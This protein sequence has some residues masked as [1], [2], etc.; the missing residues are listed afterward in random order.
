MSEKREG[1][2]WWPYLGPYLGFGLIAA[3]GD[4]LPD[5][6]APIMLIVKPGVTA[7]LIGYFWWRGAYPELRGFR[8]GSP[9]V[10]ADL[11]VGVA[12]ALLWMGPYLVFPAIRPADVSGGFDPNMLGASL[13]PA[14]VALR[15]VGYAGVTPIF[16]ELFMRSFVMRFAEVWDGKGDFRNIPIAHYTRNSFLAVVVIFTLAHLPWEYWVM[17]PW[18]ILST[19]WFYWRGHLIAVIVLHAATNGAILLIVARTEGMFLDASGNPLPL[20]FFV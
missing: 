6:A 13:A 18:A 15:M 8:W 14:V 3:V 9:W 1:H 16:E 4:R 10:L 20:W 11:A 7:A 19:L 17:V 12:L 2:G 5:A